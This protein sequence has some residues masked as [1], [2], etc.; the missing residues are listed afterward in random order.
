MENAILVQARKIGHFSSKRQHSLPCVANGSA[1]D[2]I[3]TNIMNG[4][5]QMREISEKK[6]EVKLC[7]LFHKRHSACAKSGLGYK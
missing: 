6:D 4:T 7:S 1:A 2:G 5:N 3:Y